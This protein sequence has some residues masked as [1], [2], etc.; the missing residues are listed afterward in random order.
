MI[1]RIS[2]LN[3]KSLR[4]IDVEL[5]NFHVLV[6]PNA[7]GKSTFLDTITLVADILKDGLDPAIYRRSPN[8][9][10]LVWNQCD[11]AFDLAVEFDLPSNM[12]NFFVNSDGD[13][14]ETKLFKRARYYVSLGLDQTK[15]TQILEENFALLE[16]LREE[17]ASKFEIAEARHGRKSIYNKTLVARHL[18]MAPCVMK[19]RGG[20][21]SFLSEGKRELM[22]F[23]FGSKRA[24]LM[25]V[26][27]DHA[28][29]S[30]S[31]YIRDFLREGVDFILINSE[32]MRR[33][34][35][36]GSLDKLRP[37]GSNLPFAVEHVKKA[38][39]HQ[40]DQWI[41]HLRTALPDIETIDTVERPEDRHRYLRIHYA[42]GLVAPSW[43]VSD[44][45]L[46]LLA[47]TLIAYLPEKNRVYLIEEPENGIHPR[48]LETVFQS[49]SSCYDNQVFCATHS[50]VFLSLAE[51]EQVLCFG[52][53]EDGATDIVRGSEH[54]NLRN[55]QRT[56]DLGTLLA[57]GIL[58]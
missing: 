1:R 56:T 2:A 44:G 26:P 58:G 34:A 54:P 33:P 19:S 32:A 24:A 9:N 30:I 13:T 55:W 7:S 49:L 41:E 45:T 43:T 48:A 28:Q 20:I 31:L 37:D 47:L 42:N 5:E 8:F 46:R 15:Q 52:R 22:N 38:Q 53:T 6:G 11:W 21:D 18:R 10:D 25:Y 35:P 29:F 17:E 14:V 36:P 39:P 3:Y 50:P 23:N 40:F 4:Y 27:E 16:E 57:T 12:T 51:P